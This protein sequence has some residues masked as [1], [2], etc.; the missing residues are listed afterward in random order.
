[1]LLAYSEGASKLNIT[2]ILEYRP[3]II[4]RERDT[5]ERMERVT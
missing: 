1:L 3:T 2:T 5:E 4:R